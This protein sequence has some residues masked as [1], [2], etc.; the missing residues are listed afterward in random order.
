MNRDLKLIIVTSLIFIF[1]MYIYPMVVKDTKQ[2]PNPDWQQE[3]AKEVQS[4]GVNPELMSS[5]DMVDYD[6]AEVRSVIRD[7]LSKAYNAEDAVSLAAEYVYN[8]VRYD[9]QESDYR[10]LTAPAS[11]ILASG[12]GQCDTQSRALVTIL[13]G[14]GMAATPVAGCIGFNAQCQ[15]TQAVTG[16]RGPQFKEITQEDLLAANLSRS[17]GLHTWVR[18]YIPQKGWKD[19]E[20]TAGV[21]INTGY[22]A[23]YIEE[24][25]PTSIPEEC[26]SFNRSFA[27]MCSTI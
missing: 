7:I 6:S 9:A 10:C 22:C 13:R 4:V 27:Q 21:F 3:Y 2:L 12:S 14:M 24:Y 26:M 1:L 25:I 23:K 20:A 11:Q 17:G 19:V 18:V 16:V 15:I 8:N 5:T